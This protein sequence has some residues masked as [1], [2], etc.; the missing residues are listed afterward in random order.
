MKIIAF[1]LPQFHEIP[2][3]NEWWGEGFTEWT[4][5]K[6]A[7]P[8]FEGHYQ[9][10]I[11]LN[12]NY[13]N[14]L[15]NNTLR[16]Q[17][18]LAKEYGISGFCFYHYWFDGHMLLEKPVENYLSDKSL[19]LP[20]CICWANEDWTNAWSGKSDKVLITQNYGNADEWERHFNYLLPFLKDDRYIKIDNKPLLIIYRPEIIPCLEEMIDNFR[21][22]AV[23]SGLNGL[24][25]AYQHVHFDLIPDADQSMFDYN[26]EYQPS[27][28]LASYSEQMGN[29]HVF[30]T[31]AKKLLKA[32]LNKIPYG[33][34]LQK[35]YTKIRRSMGQVIRLQYNEIWD[36]VIE[37][38]PKDEKCIPGAFVDW[39]N[40]PRKGNYGLVFQGATPSIFKDYL[41]KQIIR[42]KSIY[43]KDYIFLFAWNEWAE[44]GYLEPDEKYGYG[45]LNAI[46]EALIETDEF[47][48]SK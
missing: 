7:K 28:A 20:F 32:I 46:K 41:K 15:D 29:K 17:V 45:Y 33:N 21:E 27:Y 25:I 10:R 11:P 48:S 3:N 16:W 2:E 40:T 4:N 44:G 23:K 36:K 5:V 6:K 12:N 43:K 8:L 34:V 26:I 47:S 30:S 18:N 37:R 38:K 39:D 24:S 1:Y 9:P 19:D 31:K 13:Y 14:L 22:L 35:L 42:A